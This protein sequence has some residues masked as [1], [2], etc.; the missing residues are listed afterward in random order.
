MCTKVNVS[1]V[2]L[3]SKA[4]RYTHTKKIEAMDSF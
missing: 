2:S 1:Q 4:E 3:D